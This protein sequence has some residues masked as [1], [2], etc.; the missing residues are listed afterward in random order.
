LEFLA[1]AYKEH[2]VDQELFE[3]ILAGPIILYHNYFKSFID[4]SQDELEY[5]NWK[6][7]SDFVKYIE[8]KQLPIYD[9]KDQTGK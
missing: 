5:N 7:L 9:T 3:E 4:V 2:V 6:P 8:G 1:I